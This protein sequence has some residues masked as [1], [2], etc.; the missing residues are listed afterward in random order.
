MLTPEE[1]GRL[2][3][4]F[5][6]LDADENGIL[7]RQE[8]IER[9]VTK[10]KADAPLNPEEARLLESTNR[11]MQLADHDQDVLDSRMRGIGTTQWFEIVAGLHLDGPG[12]VDTYCRMFES[13]LH[14]RSATPLPAED[15]VC[16][17]LD[18]IT[19]GDSLN[20]V[21]DKGI[22]A[23]IDQL[24]SKDVRAAPHLIYI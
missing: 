14:V 4:I 22:E 19:D 17:K 7:S 9:F 23:A 21:D 8:F 12:M 6:T 10:I 3:A 13:R 5:D 2:A 20:R 15:H 24:L 1:I 16:C 18:A 11:A